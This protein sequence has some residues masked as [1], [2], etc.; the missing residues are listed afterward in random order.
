MAAIGHPVSVEDQIDQWRSQKP[1]RILC[2][3]YAKL[4]AMLI[5]HWLMLVG[6]WAYPDRSL[7]KAS[8]TIQAHAGALASA[9][10]DRLLG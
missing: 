4:L 10:H 5:Q 3:V 7:L 2:E 9:L 1:W 8:R 6:C